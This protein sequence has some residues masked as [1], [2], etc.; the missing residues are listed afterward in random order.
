MLEAFNF[1]VS[2]KNISVNMT[3]SY[4]C[5]I[6]SNDIAPYILNKTI[7]TPITPYSVNATLC[8][9]S[10]S[11]PSDPIFALFTNNRTVSVNNTTISTPTALTTAISTASRVNNANPYLYLILI[12][13]VILIIAVHLRYNKRNRKG[14][15]K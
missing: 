15:R 7:W 10:F 5:S 2:Q 11:I 13:I 4:S 8:A 9:V 6:N 12:I 3:L 14:F 1:S